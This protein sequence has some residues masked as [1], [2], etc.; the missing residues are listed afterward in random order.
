MS[1][2]NTPIK[3]GLNPFA[4]FAVCSVYD[5]HIPL[6]L[7]SVMCAHL[8][9]CWCLRHKY[10]HSEWLLSLYIF[11]RMTLTLF[12]I[13][14]CRYYMKSVSANKWVCWLRGGWETKTEQQSTSKLFSLLFASSAWERASWPSHP[15]SIPHSA[16]RLVES[17]MSPF[18]TRESVH[19][20]HRILFVDWS[21]VH[22]PIHVACRWMPLSLCTAYQITITQCCNKRYD[23]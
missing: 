16:G 5:S 8:L 11:A 9:L 22:R 6:W 17:T 3:S 2:A 15:H 20:C 14:L 13:W 18:W 1:S 10:M 19:H 4:A 12:E 23:S 7:I 21:N